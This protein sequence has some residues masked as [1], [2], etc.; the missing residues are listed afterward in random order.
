MGDSNYLAKDYLAGKNELGS[1]AIPIYFNGAPANEAAFLSAGGAK[2]QGRLFFECGNDTEHKNIVVIHDGKV[3]MAS[4]SGNVIFK[5]S[6]KHKGY[7]GYVK[8]LPITIQSPQ[9]SI[10]EV[11]AILASMTANRY[12]YSGTFREIKDPGNLNALQHITNRAIPTPANPS[13]VNLLY[14]LSSFELETL[15]AKL[16]EEAGCFVPAYRGGNMIGADIFAY[17]DTPS[18][19]N[20]AGLSILPGKKGVSIQVKRSNMTLATPPAG[21]DYLVGIALKPSTSNFDHTWF[22]NA[23]AT[24]SKTKEWLKRSL[25]WLPYAY[26]A[27]NGLP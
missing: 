18:A 11:P 26:R 13:L 17:N 16:L 1:P 27:A 4:P 3:T 10:T 7:N 24:P 21:V 20:I 23:L 19:I 25:H 22:L 15:V 14:C 9:L 2:E 8:L 12:Y 5:P 6:T